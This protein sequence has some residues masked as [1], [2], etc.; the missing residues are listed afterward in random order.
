MSY[1]NKSK[2][3]GILT[4][5]LSNSLEFRLLSKVS[6]TSINLRDIEMHLS[7]GPCL[8]AFMLIC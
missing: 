7:V 8:C 5:K 3:F 2:D 1:F 4:P 6:T